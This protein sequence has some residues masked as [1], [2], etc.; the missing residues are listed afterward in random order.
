MNIFDIMIIISLLICLSI[1]SYLGGA[2]DGYKKGQIDAIN[3]EIHYQLEKQQNGET[4][5]VEIKNG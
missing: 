4:E 2:H 1:M 3:G 5:W